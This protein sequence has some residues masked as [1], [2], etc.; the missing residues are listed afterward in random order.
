M[1]RCSWQHW[2]TPPTLRMFYETLFI[3][4]WSIVVRCLLS[5]NTVKRRH[6]SSPDPH[7][8]P[9]SAKHRRKKYFY[10]GCY[11]NSSWYISNLPVSWVVW[12]CVAHTASFV[13][14]HFY[15][16]L[17]FCIHGHCQNNSLG[18]NFHFIWCILVYDE[19]STMQ[20]WFIYLLTLL[21]YSV[22]LTDQFWYIAWSHMC[23]T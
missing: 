20:N 10:N 9:R 4:R 19:L 22:S 14:W 1:N 13:P 12:G 6:H 8:I 23:S 17:W 7:E 3:P 16:F 18:L 11:N 5:M 2:K 21:N 15:L